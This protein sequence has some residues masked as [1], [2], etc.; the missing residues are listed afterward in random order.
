MMKRALAL[1]VWASM[2]KTST[3]P[4]E[5]SKPSMYSYWASVANQLSQR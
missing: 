2:V 5:T 4:I 1:K 3:P